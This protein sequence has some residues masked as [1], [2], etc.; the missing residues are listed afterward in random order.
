MYLDDLP[1]AAIA[2]R[3]KAGARGRAITEDGRARA[4]AFIG[5]GVSAPEQW[6][7]R[8]DIAEGEDGRKLLA[9]AFAMTGATTLW[10]FGGDAVTRQAVTDL[11]LESS[12]DLALFVRRAE[13]VP[14]GGRLNLRAAPDLDAQTRRLVARHLDHYE[15]PRFAAALSG[16]EIVGYAVLQELTPTWSEVST[17]V[18]P[19]ARR[20][21]YGA[22]ILAKSADAAENTGRMVCAAVPFGDTAARGVVERAGFRLADYYFTAKPRPKNPLIDR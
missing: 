18:F 14:S 7:V 9:D 16:G 4:V 6:I 5:D 19:L 13:P 21:G 12:P 11:N 10:Y 17:F 8:F 1:D 20:H 15:S 2:R 3:I 22:E